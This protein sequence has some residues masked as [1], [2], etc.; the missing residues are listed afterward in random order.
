[1]NRALI[2]KKSTFIVRK[3][4][5]TQVLKEEIYVAIH[6]DAYK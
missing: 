3:K 2:L 4:K 1:M 5:N 6:Y